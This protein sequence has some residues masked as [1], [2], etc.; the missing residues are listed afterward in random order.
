M[1]LHRRRLGVVAVPDVV[2]Q[3]LREVVGL[4]LF[5]KN[6]HDH[7]TTGY[8]DGLNKPYEMIAFS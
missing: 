3:E 8:V 1:L 4:K 2:G 5:E 7:Q 6:D